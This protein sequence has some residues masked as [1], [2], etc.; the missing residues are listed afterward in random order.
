MNPKI[1]EKDGKRILITSVKKIGNAIDANKLFGDL[2]KV[3]QMDGGGK[4][5]HRHHPAQK[6]INRFSGGYMSP[7]MLKGFND[8]AASQVF[9]SLQPFIPNAAVAI[10]QTVHSIF[11]EF[12]NLEP[13]E[14]KTEK[15]FEFMERLIK[16][17]D[18]EGQRKVIEKYVNG[19]IETPDYR[20][21]SKPMDHK[22][23]VCYN[24]VFM[25]GDVSPLGVPLPFPIYSLSDRIDFFEEDGET[26]AYIIDYKTGTWLNNKAATMDGYLPQAICYKWM[27]EQEYGVPVKGAYLLVPGTKQKI[28]ELDVNSLTNQSKYI[29]RIYKFKEEFQSAARTRIYEWRKPPYM[30]N[31]KQK[32]F[33][34]LFMN[35]AED[36]EIQIEYDITW[37]PKE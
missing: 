27:V 28:V 4:K 7:T 19:F 36:Q 11:E 32:A 17:K 31:E 30:G 2:E 15:L 14:R 1:I 34:E 16:E 13:E 26:V 3:V 6:L 12:Y 9:Q 22:S 10:G 25:K 20:D 35:G 29:E 37:E 5:L 18:Q 23:L 8:S 33:N 24:E 21:P